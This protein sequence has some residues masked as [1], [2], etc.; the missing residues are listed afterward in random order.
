MGDLPIGHLRS[1]ETVV[2]FEVGIPGDTLATH[3]GIFATTGMGKSNLMMVLAGGVHAGQRPLRPAAHRPARR[4][5][6][7][8]RPPP[9][10]R[11]P[12][13]HLRG[14]PPP[15]HLH[16]AA[17][18]RRAHRRRPPHRV[19]LEPA[20]GGGAVRARAPLLARGPRRPR[21]GCCRSPPSTT[22]PAS[23]TSSST[24]ASRSTRC[25]SCTAAPA[26]SSTC[27]ASAADPGVSV[28]APIVRDLA[29]G[30]VV[31]VD[32]SGLGSTEEVLVASFL[33]RRVLDR[34]Q[35]AYLDD[36][37]RHE[38]LPVG[39]D[40]ARG[41]AARAVGEQGPG[42][43]RVPARRARGPQVQGRPVRDHPAAQAAR[44]RA[45]QPV[46]HLLRPRPG[47]REGPQHPAG[48]GQAGPQR[49]RPRDPDA[50]AG[51]VPRRQPGRAVRG[52]GQGPPVRRRRA[53]HAAAARARDQSPPANVAALVD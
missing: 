40:R 32:V 23:A 38:T 1:G 42:V 43:Q 45:A 10:G 2:D 13:A 31:L 27:S 6:Q 3:V 14:A 26:A 4:V 8:A 48:V 24:A 44:R 5:P 47:R 35:D 25:R 33:A 37:E 9:V 30:K 15:E 52:A 39:G 20:A 7:R 50:D 19:R 53:R 28:G 29:E 34:W 49:A 36:P 21:P 18:P 12:A 22:C 11:R 17:Q 41:G 51:R 46:Q 16:P